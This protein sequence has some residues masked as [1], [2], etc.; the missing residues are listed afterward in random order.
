M[1]H[2][3]FTLDYEIYGNGQGSLKELVY[4]PTQKLIN[5]F[6]EYD[7]KFVNFIEVAELIKIKEYD[8]DPYIS[9]VENQIQEMYSNGFE[10]GLHIHPQWFNASFNGTAWNL[11]YDEYNLCKIGKGKIDKYI[12]ICIR[13]LKSL[14]GRNYNPV[15]FR[16]GG[17]LIQPTV[18]IY[19]TLID[20]G[21]QVDSSVFK[22]G[23]S[24]YYG[25]DFRKSIGNGYYWKFSND[26]NAEDK[27]GKLIEIPIYTKMVHP[28]KMISQN[29]IAVMNKS[30][31]KTKM[32]EKLYKWGDRL[33]I[34]YPQK[35]DFTKMTFEEL[36]SMTDE[37]ILEDKPTP[38]I[39]KP[40]V[41]IGHAKNLPKLSEIRKFLSYVRKKKP[42]VT[43]F[44]KII[45]QL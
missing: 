43:T 24:R 19:Q 38:S 12:K 1:I 45:K 41:L 7:Y 31:K 13:Y 36:R 28:W 17:W 27:R 14:L 30:K 44:S 25:L 29:R 34:K 37:I 2:F 8:S 3:I 16:A 11:D 15:S 39:L 35:F 33:R 26:V 42:P 4:G 21:I 9:K 32:I 10:I 40:I 20:S 22:G 5:L 6:N 18:N 23:L